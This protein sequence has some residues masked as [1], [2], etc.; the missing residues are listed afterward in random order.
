MTRR[1]CGG[2]GSKWNRTSEQ[3]QMALGI[4]ARNLYS[5]WVLTGVPYVMYGSLKFTLSRGSR[6]RSH[7]VAVITSALHAEG[8]QFDPGWDQFFLFVLLKIRIRR[9]IWFE[10]ET[11][12]LWS[13]SY[14]ALKHLLRNARESMKCIE[15]SKNRSGQNDEENQHLGFDCDKRP[16]EPSVENQ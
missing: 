13:A 9:F 2:S 3:I 8:L 6:Q 11:N 4:W 12:F 16:L 1:E 14:R 7:S 5:I 15:W 10:N